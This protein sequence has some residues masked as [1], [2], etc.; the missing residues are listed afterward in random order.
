MKTVTTKKETCEIFGTKSTI[1]LVNGIPCVKLTSIGNGLKSGY[2]SRDKFIVFNYSNTNGISY[3]KRTA[4][5]INDV[6]SYL[7]K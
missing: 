3:W 5:T 6:I 4:R 7:S 2:D 1:I